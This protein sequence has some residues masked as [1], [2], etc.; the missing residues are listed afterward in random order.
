MKGPEGSQILH[1]TPPGILLGVFRTEDMFSK[2]EK[3]RFVGCHCN[4]CNSFELCHTHAKSRRRR[5]RAHG[6]SDVLAENAVKVASI[7]GVSL[8]NNSFGE[9]WV[10]TFHQRPF[11][12]DFWFKL[13]CTSICHG[14]W[15]DSSN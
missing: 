13:Q 6:V 10:V 8:Q 1:F 5:R 12:F 2:L 4:T 9:I 14:T 11:C 7:K 15:H 3:D